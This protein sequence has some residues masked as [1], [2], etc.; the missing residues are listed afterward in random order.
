MKKLIIFLLTIFIIPTSV[1]ASTVEEQRNAVIKTAEAYYSQGSQLEY[2]SYKKNLY[3]TPEDATS[4]HHVYTVCSGLTFMSYYQSLGIKIPHSTETLLDYAKANKSNKNIVVYYYDSKSSSK[5]AQQAFNEILTK[6]INKISPGDILVWTGHAMMVY[7][8]NPTNHTIKIIHANGGRYDFEN[9]QDLIDKEGAI[10]YKTLSSLDTNKERI[11]L[12]KIITDGKTFTDAEGNKVNYD[13]SE[14]AKTRM[15]YPSIDIG[16]IINNVNNQ[17]FASIN[18]TLTYQLRIRNKGK[19]TY[20]NISVEEIIDQNLTLIDKGTATVNGNKLSWVIP[21]IKPG[22]YVTLLYTVKVPNNIDGK[23]VVSVGTVEGIKTSRIETLI[24]KRLSNDEKTILKN[25]FEKIKNNSSATTSRGFINELYEKALNI[26]LNIT[27]LKN[28]DVL[29]YSETNKS[30]GGKT[31]S[32]KY[33]TI[34]DSIKKYLYSNFYGLRIA[35]NFNKD[36]NY[37]KA[38]LAWNFFPTYELNDKAR[39]INK[40]M[41][42]DGDIILAYL[43]RNSKTDT[44]MGDKGYIYLNNALYRYRPTAT[45]NKFEIISGTTLDTFL[46]DLV[47]ENFIILRPYTSKITGIAMSMLPD[48]TKYKLNEK[49]L[50]LTNGTIKVLYDDNT[51]EIINLDNKNVKIT[52]FNTT[53]PGTKTITV[54]YKSYKTTFNIEVVQKKLVKVEITNKPNKTTY[55]K[56]IET[57]DVTGGELKLYYNDNS[58]E[59]IN[60]KNNK[61]KVTGFDNTQKGS[62]EVIVT[63]ENYINAFKVNIIEKKSAIVVEEKPLKQTYSVNSEKLDL[64]GGFLTIIKEDGTKENISL[65]NKEVKVSGFDNKTVGITYVTIE[66]K[67]AKA[68]FPVEI[69]DKEIESI[70]IEELPIK[71]NYIYTK[72]NLD[73]TGGVANITYK[74]G[75]QDKISLTNENIKI[76]NFD[77]NKVGTNN[78][79]VNYRN[80]K[81]T[82]NVTVVDKKITGIEVTTLPTKTTY[83]KN[84]ESL[85]L[86]EGILTIYYDDNTSDQMSLT[87]ENIKVY[88]FNNTKLETNNLEVEYH[89]FKTNFGVEIIEDFNFD[90]D[91]ESDSIFDNIPPIVYIILAILLIIIALPI[92]IVIIASKKNK[93]RIQK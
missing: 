50:K 14:S 89:G 54:E 49:E 69:I 18:D 72:E 60:F 34:N 88:G 21:E 47:G 23:I 24:G 80:V 27:D 44:E 42:E 38:S 56:D 74:D 33:T 93:N 76:S 90:L 17:H 15:K 45:T 46:N 30:A 48:V 26:N 11:A 86:S 81:T 77:N 84:Q 78:I 55:I 82:F 64:T 70:K 37:V 36:K 9:H 28:L 67:N 16:K 20:Q 59:I 53:T 3:S 63:Y 41:L 61:V 32:I 43:G 83:I 13:I 35:E 1:F 92:I 58:T 4:K 68:E 65:D 85:D 87:N 5:T 31:L 12:I 25:T 62:R 66:Y 29:K 91:V 75:T 8:V 57:L 52:G 22:E 73:L 7:E 40:S 51:S 79:E 6:H 19:Q 10:S 71:T 39:T 2:D